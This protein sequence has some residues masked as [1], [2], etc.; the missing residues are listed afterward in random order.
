MI[1]HRPM[2]FTQEWG[3]LHVCLWF[4]SSCASPDKVFV[5]PVEGKASSRFWHEQPISGFS[6]CQ[7]PLERFL[8]VSYIC[9]LEVVEALNDMFNALL[10]MHFVVTSANVHSV[11]GQFLFSNNCNDRN[12]TQIICLFSSHTNVHIHRK[13]KDLGHLLS[14]SLKEKE[15]FSQAS[16]DQE[17]QGI[18]LSYVLGYYN[19][20][21]T[22]GQ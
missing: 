6:W 9:V 12:S 16:H 8:C 2:Q 4:T 5:N 15:I 17:T 21:N 11:I 14:F 13:L 10:P 1:S 20:H 19:D 7:Y 18:I 22:L 3:G